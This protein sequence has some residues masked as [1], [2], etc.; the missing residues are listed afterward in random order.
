MRGL[1]PQLEGAK[2]RGLT[3]AVVP[4]ANAIEAGIV[5]DIDVRLASCLED[6]VA[7]FARRATLPRATTTPFAPGHAAANGDLSEVRGQGGAPAPRLGNRGRG[8][9][10]P[11]L[12]RPS[13]KRQDPARATPPERSPSSPLRGSGGSHR[14]PQRCRP[15]PAGRGHRQ[16]ATLSRSPS[17]RQR[18]GCFVGGGEVPRR[19]G[20]SRAPRRAVS[21]RARRVSPKRARSAPPTARRRR[22][23]YRASASASVVSRTSA[24]RRRRQPVSVRLFRAPA[25]ALRVL[26][27]TLANATECD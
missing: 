10:Q 16:R 18:S 21:R 6:V 17:L 25:A 7:Y 27:T 22:G 3:A 24:G 26:K 8:C 4:R 14:N 23:A 9:P 11:P 13:G 19:R 5:R 12:H 20:E 15:A 2:L 1:L